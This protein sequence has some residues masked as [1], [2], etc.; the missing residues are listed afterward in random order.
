MA[1]L[2][3]GWSLFSAAVVGASRAVNENVI[4]P[5]IEKVSDPALQENVRGYLTEAQKRA[6]LAGS[7]ANQWSKNQ[8][9][10]DVAEK[11]EGVRG[12]LGGGP[13]REGY[14][15]VPQGYDG[16]STSLYHDQSDDDDAFFD[17]HSS[18]SQSQTTPTASSTTANKKKE[19][20]DDDW[21]DF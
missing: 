8:F 17:R 2:S 19:D 11:V 15:S 18:Q 13:S 21:K 4:Q 20:W 12:K 3:K 6:A 16:E 14:G 9:G 7:T 10:V 5:G 1:A